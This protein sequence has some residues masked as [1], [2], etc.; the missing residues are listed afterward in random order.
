[1]RDH[2]NVDCMQD[3]GV[4]VGIQQME[5]NTLSAQHLDSIGPY[6][7]TGGP[8]SVAAGRISFIYGLKGPAVSALGI[9]KMVHTTQGSRMQCLIIPQQLCPA[10]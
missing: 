9:S 10:L 5:Y 1:M 7:A 8:F 6:S 3:M 4:F 2:N